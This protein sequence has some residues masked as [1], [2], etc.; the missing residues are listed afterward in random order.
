MYHRLEIWDTE[1][2]RRFVHSCRKQLA[3]ML[4]DVQVN[5]HGSPAQMLCF[6]HQK[7]E[8][9]DHDVI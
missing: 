1:L 7:R 4:A 9:D 5:W 6:S 3:G 2:M 8:A